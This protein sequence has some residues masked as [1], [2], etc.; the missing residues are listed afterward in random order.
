MPA[1]SMPMPSQT[2]A[3]PNMRGS[4]AE[5]TTSVS[6]SFWKN[7]A[8]VKP[9]LISDSDVRIT[10]ISVR[11]ALMRVRWKDMPVRRF[12][13]STEMSSPVCGNSS[14]LLIPAPAASHRL[15]AQLQEIALQEVVQER[16]DDGDRRYPRDRFPVGR[17]RGLDD[18]GSQLECEAGDQP[19]R[20][21]EPD[22][23]T[24]LRGRPGEAD[25]QHPDDGLDR[26][27]DDHHER[28]GID[29][30][31]RVLRDDRQPLAHRLTPLRRGPGPG[32]AAS[33]TERM[34]R[35]LRSGTGARPG[36]RP[37]PP[38]RP[39]AGRRSQRRDAVSPLREPAPF[40]CRDPDRRADA[41]RAAQPR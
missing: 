35:W 34:R 22:L 3:M 11:S 24:L 6:F 37:A 14:A 18:V 32:R 41:P 10:D 20:V 36:R 13:S 15:T 39:R 33:G 30:E 8:I 31:D 26:A 2:S 9:K 16:P 19:A 12:E 4:C 23:A 38:A 29:P 7:C 25:A 40:G 17:D 28:G 1:T 21:V 5:V 27:G